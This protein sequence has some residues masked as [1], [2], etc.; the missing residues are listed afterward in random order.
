MH[1]DFFPQ[2]TYII[3]IL[4]P[5]TKSMSIYATDVCILYHLPA[6]AFF[7]CYFTTF[8]FPS[9]RDL[10]HFRMYTNSNSVVCLGRFT[11]KVDKSYFKFLSRSRRQEMK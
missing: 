10:T 11:F 3:I 2:T 4:L 5:I 1:L 8:F 7:G 9:P 6:L